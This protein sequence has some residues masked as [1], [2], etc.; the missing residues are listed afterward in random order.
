MSDFNLYQDESIAILTPV[1]AAGKDWVAVNIP[2]E[3][4]HYAGGVV[5]E[6]R[7]ISDI[8]EG[9]EADGLELEQ[10]GL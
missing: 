9:I 8:V 3:A 1:S 2:D 10:R 7:F 5:I 4:T 6:N